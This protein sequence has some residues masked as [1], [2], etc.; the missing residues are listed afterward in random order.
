MEELNNSELVISD[1]KYKNLVLG[2]GS[3]KGI[4][5]LGAIQCLMDEKLLDLKKLGAIAGTSIGSLIALLIVLDFSIEE[6]WQFILN[7]DIKKMFQP[8]PLNFLNFCGADNGR[9][10]YDI[11]EDIITKKT[12]IKHINFKQLYDINK[13]HLIVVGT[14]LTTKEVKYYDYINTPTFKVSMSVRISIG[15]PGFFMP[16]TIDNKKYI[17]GGMMNNY[18][19]NL[20]ED[21][22]H[23]TIGIQICCNYNTEYEWPEEFL[24]AIINLFMY[25]YYKKMG[26]PY[27]NNTITIK[28]FSDDITMYNF[29]ITNDT[30]LKL[31]QKGID[32]CKEFIKLI[33]EHNNNNDGDTSSIDNKSTVNNKIDTDVTESEICDKNEI[34]VDDNEENK[35]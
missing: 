25:N 34:V 23:E 20:F 19:M 35:I 33:K 2:G 15:L 3:I 27:P 1:P 22:L 7:I 18:P 26:Q 16:I 14:C 29:D 24:M 13:I 6:I 11:I 9:R 8:N 30:K 17:D 12:G 5:T 28:D 31:Y 21:K 4:S 10:I 32:A